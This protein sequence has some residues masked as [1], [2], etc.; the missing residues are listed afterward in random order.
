M[1][2]SSS[3]R[4]CG[5]KNAWQLGAETGR[6]PR[7][8]SKLTTLPSEYIQL[9]LL[10][11]VCLAIVFLMTATLL[12]IATVPAARATVLRGLEIITAF[13]TR[14]AEIFRPSNGKSGEG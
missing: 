7:R 5:G 10:G 14:L 9:L 3:H 6:L 4:P 11:L 8:K 2:S 13:L 12:V 1:L